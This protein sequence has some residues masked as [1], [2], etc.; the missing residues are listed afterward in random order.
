MRP[1]H[2]S[3]L[4][5]GLASMILAAGLS[6]LAQSPAG[7]LQGP[8]QAGG[9]AGRADVVEEE[10]G[11]RDATPPGT[12]ERS[13]PVFPPKAARLARLGS[14][15][16]VPRQEEGVEGPPRPAGKPRSDEGREVAPQIG[17]AHV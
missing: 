12:P 1:A 13:F 7:P 9:G 2:V 4:L 8:G 5:I 6:S 11:G 17:R 15:L 16:A 3:R 14:A 10:T